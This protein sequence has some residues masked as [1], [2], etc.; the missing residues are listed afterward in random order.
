MLSIL[1]VSSDC[2]AAAPTIKCKCDCKAWAVQIPLLDR[3]VSLCSTYML[4]CT[5][6]GGIQSSGMGAERLCTDSGKS[7]CFCVTVQNNLIILLAHPFWKTSLIYLCPTFW[8]NNDCPFAAW[9]VISSQALHNTVWNFQSTPSVNGAST[10][11][12]YW[13][14]YTDVVLWRSAGF[15]LK[16]G[17]CW[18]W[19]QA[20]AITINS[21]NWDST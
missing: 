18:C 6:S 4:S 20:S 15:E 10:E 8:I 16:S 21:S 3:A 12:V 1:I 11:V 2:T 19:W 5:G 7:P 13:S 9:A 17:S 14:R